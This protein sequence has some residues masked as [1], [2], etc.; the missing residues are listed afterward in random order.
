MPCA[1]GELYQIQ[2]LTPV[3]MGGAAAVPVP[4]PAEEP[5]ILAYVS[6]RL[7]CRPFLSKLHTHSC[8]D[9]RKTT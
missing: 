3:A 6:T 5:D 8:R 4:I 9:P 7:S 1:E 2:A